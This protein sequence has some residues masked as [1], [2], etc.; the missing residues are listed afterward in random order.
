MP[1]DLENLATIRSNILTKLA[2]EPSSPKVSYSID[3]QTVNYNDWYRMMWG[4]LQEVNKQIA[5]SGGPFEVETLGL[6]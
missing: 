1:S 3:G 6:V 4:Q 5:A 2:S